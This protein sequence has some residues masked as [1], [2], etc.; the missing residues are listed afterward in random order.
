ML[1]SKLFL[2][3]RYVIKDMNGTMYSDYQLEEAVNTVQNIIANALSVS[4]SELLTKQATITMTS[5]V[6]DLPTDFRSIV[7]VF[8]SS[9]EPLPYLTKSKAVDEF[10]YR[11]RGNKIY[12]SNGTLIV[13][14]K[15]SLTDA[16]ISNLAVEMDL[17][18]YFAD[19]I[20]K[21]AVII[22]QNGM[23]NSD[24]S[25]VQLISDDVYN[26]TS[27]REYSGLEITPAFSF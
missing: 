15:K 26:L 7:S 24:S 2:S 16:D 22:L 27:G 3:L 18:N 11:I 6:G 14:Y 23:S 20:K 1:F 5:G 9:N 19:T 8:N 4:N 17:P 10:S 13:D 21:Y 25:M 12:S